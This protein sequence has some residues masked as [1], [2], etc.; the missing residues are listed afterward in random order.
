[1]AAQFSI[2][3]SVG[4]AAVY[5]DL[6]LHHF[7]D[8]AIKDARVL[9]VAAKV[10]AVIEPEF[11]ALISSQ[12]P[13][14]IEIETKQGKVG[15]LRAEYPKGSPENPMTFDECLDKFRKCTDFSV[16]PLP[17]ENIEEVIDLVGRLEEVRDITALVRLLA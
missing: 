5:R 4:T 12:A 15:P 8:E 2:P 7:T 9:E 17:R 10:K 11:T 14:R 1:M 13:V 3:Y 16:K 6:S